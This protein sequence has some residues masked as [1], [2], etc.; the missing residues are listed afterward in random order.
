MTDTVLEPKLTKWDQRV[1]AAL[2]EW[3]KG[4]SFGL[5]PLPW[6]SAWAVAEK[7]RE[8]NVTTVRQTLNAL[9]DFGY[10]DVCGHGHQRLWIR[11]PDRRKPRREPV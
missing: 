9:M 11:L 7:V 4:W 2:G 6:M 5:A 8:D 1:L 3:P 10:A